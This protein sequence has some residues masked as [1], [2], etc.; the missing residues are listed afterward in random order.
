MKINPSDKRE[1]GGKI[2]G[3]CTCGREVQEGKNNI[4]PLCGNIL[5]WNEIDKNKQ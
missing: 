2:Y 1:L 3:Y 5:I 4:C